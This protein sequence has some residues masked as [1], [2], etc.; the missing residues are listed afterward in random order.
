MPTRHAELSRE[1][2]KFITRMRL[3]KGALHLLT[4][5]G[6]ASLTASK[7][8]RVAGIAQPSFYVHFR[9]KDDLLETLARE[10]FGTLRASLRDTRARLAIQGESA[11]LQS[12]SFI[13]GIRETFRISLDALL[14]DPELFRL[15]VGERNE[16][17]SPLGRYARELAADLH[18]ELVEDLVRIGAPVSTEEQ[19]EHLEMAACGMISLTENLGMELLNGRFRNRDR[20]LDM[21]VTF[22]LSALPFKEG[23]A[24]TTARQ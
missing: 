2:A 4:R 20:I 6:Y 9:D 3:L 12:L 15:Y 11:W 21:L 24:G 5:E 19:R 10:K 16:P 22:A 7:V 17:N 14:A 13:A 1:E 8:S 23:K 18:R